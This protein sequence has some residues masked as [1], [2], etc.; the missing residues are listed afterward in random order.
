VIV[1]GLIHV[2]NGLTD[3]DSNQ[4]MTPEFTVTTTENFLWL[5]LVTKQSSPRLKHALWLNIYIVNELNHRIPRHLYFND[6]DEY[7]PMTVG[8]CFK[9]FFYNVLLSPLSLCAM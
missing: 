4:L 8:Y 9:G 6:L 3:I 5:D 1:T 2:P 7:G